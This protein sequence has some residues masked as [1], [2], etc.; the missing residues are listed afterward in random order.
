MAAGGA[1]AGTEAS[2]GQE[3]R[4]TECMAV[5][6][7]PWV[8]SDCSDMPSS[9]DSLLAVQASGWIAGHGGCPGP[10]CGPRGERASGV[11][12]GQSHR[13]SCDN[14]SGGSHV[15]ERGDLQRR[16]RAALH[17]VHDGGR[18]PVGLRG[19][20][21]WP[22]AGPRRGGTAAEVHRVAEGDADDV[23]VHV[24][25]L[26]GGRIESGQLAG[27]EEGSALVVVVSA[28]SGAC[29]GSTERRVGE[30]GS[31]LGV[32]VS[33]RSGACRGS[34]ERRVE[35]YAS[36]RD[37][38][39]RRDP[40]RVRAGVARSTEQPGVRLGR[41]HVY[42]CRRDPRLRLVVIHVIVGRSVSKRLRQQLRLRVHHV[43][44]HRS[45]GG[46][47]LDLYILLPSPILYGVWHEQGGS[48]AGR[49][50]RNGRP[51]VLQ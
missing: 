37:G 30:E 27:S 45:R 15:A 17:R 36:P 1:V 49:I 41:R 2:A 8:A 26:G 42:H 7:G 5:I 11:G 38:R 44:E 51:I 22:Q 33:A 40:S 34:T 48:V 46:E 4:Y 23:H 13:P 18:H 31:A 12:D 47:R 39:R 25:G 28:R 35:G 19:G 21:R 10:D 29:R 16:A 6:N 9:G 3:P 32:L 24:D 43:Q 50:L 14:C 20:R